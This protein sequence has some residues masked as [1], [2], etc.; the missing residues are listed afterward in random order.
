MNLREKIKQDLVAVM[1]QLKVNSS[2]F[3][4]S[5]IEV[6]RPDNPEYGDYSTN[7]ALKLAS[8][9]KQSPREF[10]KK[11]A[12]R[13]KRQPYVEKLEVADPG[14]LN[15]FIKG[16]VWQKQVGEVLKQGDKFGSNDFGKG[17]SARVEFVS[18]NPTG[19]LHFGNAR[20]GPIGDV[21]ASVLEFCGFRVLREYYHNDIGGQVV[22]LGQSIIN[23]KRGGDLNDQEYKGEYILDLIK[24][25][26][27][28]S[29]FKF[30]IS[31]SKKAGEVAVAIVLEDVIKDCQDMGINFDKIYKESE[32][33]S[34]GK[35]EKALK[36]LEKKKALKKHE[37]ATWFAPHD[38]WLNDRET[39][40]VK[41]DG[42]FTYLANDVAYHK[43][44]FED[45]AE[46]VI[47]V[48]GS[49]HHGHVPRLRA[50]V[51]SLGYDTDKFKV[52]LYQWVR[53]KSTGELIKMSKRSG[54]FV[55]AREVLD[56]I[57]RDVL[58]FFILM[59]DAATHIDFDL[60]LAKEKSAKNPVYYVQYAHARIA[61]ILSKAKRLATNAKK[62]ESTVNFELLTDLHELALIKQV[63]R[64]PELV[65]DIA[66]NFAVNQ[67]TT[68]AVGLADSFH[69]FY[70][71]IRVLEEN[72]E[73]REA[74]LALITAT[75][76]T[77]ENT[78][79][80]LGVSAPS[81]M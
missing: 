47:D 51:E 7:V 64:L 74:R 52:I 33:I 50:V 46:L 27:K 55:T 26:K 38:K 60:D 66:W 54:T 13:L 20:G 10:A 24:Q 6:I 8:R 34:S 31:N 49:N 5:D 63:S 16:E 35:T 1:K 81:K 57:G 70:E 42:D 75:K 77:F 29:N 56:E 71:N 65:E 59:H 67:L 43:L 62:A 30:Q 80:L 25:I 28:I 39:V 69:K 36:A 17:K 72:R 21:L 14:F 23:V 41:S 73:V 18:A 78:L 4:V 44:K 48:L 11:L 79:K 61:S 58:R 68:Y 19:P 15:F 45:K 2:Q 40:V 32:F 37:G 9:I 22:K 76:I 12:D 3:T 53:F